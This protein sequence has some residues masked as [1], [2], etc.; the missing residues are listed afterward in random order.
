MKR[1]NSRQKGCRGERKVRDLFR[2][3]GFTARR[4]QQYSGT[5]GTSDVKVEELPTLHIESKSTEKKAFLAW[6]DQA[7]RDAAGSGKT[8]IVIHVRNHDKEP[9]L[10]MRA[11]PFIDIVRRS[12]LVQPPKDKTLVIDGRE[13]DLPDLTELVQRASG[14]GNNDI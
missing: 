9:I 12:D 1:I 7:E 4:T 6:L 5:E 3:F 10:I 8:P 13:V 2:E 11:R 14:L